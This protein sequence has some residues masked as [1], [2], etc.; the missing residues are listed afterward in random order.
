MRDAAIG[1]LLAA[2]LLAVAS[3]LLELQEPELE[4]LAPM[5]D[6]P[7]GLGTPVHRWEVAA[8]YLKCGPARL[9]VTCGAG[10]FAVRSEL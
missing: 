10:G 6:A 3:W 4:H 1:A 9:V 7:A 5:L 2:V 8:T